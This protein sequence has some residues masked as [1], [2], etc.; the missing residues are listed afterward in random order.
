MRALWLGLG[1]MGMA[2][3]CSSSSAEAVAEAVITPAQAPTKVT[4]VAAELTPMPVVLQVT[5]TLAAEQEAQ[6]GADVGGIVTDVRFELGQHVSKGDIL[7]VLDTRTSK[8]QAA[9]SIAQ[10][11]AQQAQLATLD[12]DCARTEKLFA[13]KAISQA[14]YDRTM[15]QCA[16]QREALQAAKASASAAGALV[17]RAQIRAPFSG[18][19]GE[20]LVEVG[21]FL[22]GPSPIASLYADGPLLVR[23][24]VPEAQA[25]QI[26]VGSV[27]RVFPSAAPDKV[28]TGTVRSLGG[29]LRSRTRDLVVEALLDAADPALRP[30]MFARVEVEGTAQPT[31]SV[32]ENALRESGIAKH[33]FVVREGRAFELVARTGLSRDGRVAILTDLNP[34]DLVVLDPPA[35]LRDGRQVE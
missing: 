6:I 7:A 4:T 2:A 11:A 18:V 14:Q 16:A 27:V 5:G 32:P 20:K 10:A 35:D 33:L 17:D 25:T 13:E 8:A 23:L 30:G 29:A 1:L 31:L 34:G 26:A 19:I 15:G 24:T 28:A 9:A 3:G 22:Q 12:Q 21:Q